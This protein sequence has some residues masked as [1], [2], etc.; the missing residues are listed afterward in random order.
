MIPMR[1]SVAQG[2]TI[3]SV[4]QR[5]YISPASE[6]IPRA[7]PHCSFQTGS[8]WLEAYTE[9]QLYQLIISRSFLRY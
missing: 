9:P 8:Q 5:L 3:V 1:T 7:K 6:A 2:F 4:S